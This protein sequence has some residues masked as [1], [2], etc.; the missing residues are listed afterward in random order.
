M[1]TLSASS[2]A[3]GFLAGGIILGGVVAHARLTMTAHGP[4]T[5]GVTPGTVGRLICVAENQVARQG[6]GEVRQ[7]ILPSPGGTG[8]VM[9]MAL[10]CP[11]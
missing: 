10:I 5:M 11:A 3:A 8:R 6:V 2:F 7:S 4:D 1:K 9:V